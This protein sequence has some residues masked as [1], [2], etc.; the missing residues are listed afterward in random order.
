[1]KE[2]RLTHCELGFLWPGVKLKGVST[3]KKKVYLQISFV[4]FFIFG[5]SRRL[6]LVKSCTDLLYDL[7]Y[8]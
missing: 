5:R 4:C 7:L 1:M 3:T 8:G 2:C 6:V